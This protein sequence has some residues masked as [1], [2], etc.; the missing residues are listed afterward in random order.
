MSKNSFLFTFF[1]LPQPSL[2]TFIKEVVPMPGKV[3][4]MQVPSKV[5]ERDILDFLLLAY[6]LIDNYSI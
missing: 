1:L 5:L 4:V 2:N 3:E 6:L